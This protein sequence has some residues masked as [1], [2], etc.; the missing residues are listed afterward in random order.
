LRSQAQSRQPPIAP[1]FCPPS[2]ATQAGTLGSNHYGI[3]TLAADDTG[4]YTAD[5]TQAAI[6]QLGAGQSLTDSFT[7]VS[8]EKISRTSRKVARRASA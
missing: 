6:Q 3:F 4:T 8:R 5:N 2:F 1:R 7:A